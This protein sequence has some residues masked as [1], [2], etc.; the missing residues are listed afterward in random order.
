[1]LKWNHLDDLE[2][3]IKIDY[4]LVESIVI[5]QSWDERAYVTLWFHDPTIVFRSPSGYTA[6]YEHTLYPLISWNTLGNDTLTIDIPRYTS[7]YTNLHGILYGMD[8]YK[9]KTYINTI[10]ETLW[11]K[12]ISEI[13]YLPGWMKLFITYKWK[14]VY[15][16]L[17]QEVN[18]QLAKLVDMENR[19]PDF[20]NIWTID[21]WSI[22]D[23]IVR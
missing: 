5:A 2:K 21:V 12:H 23:S 9:L 6:V 13:I 1:L 10:Q 22:D 20:V 16:H 18:R 14:K 17:D 7:G 8:E 4:P 3:E 19:Y 11:A 15:F